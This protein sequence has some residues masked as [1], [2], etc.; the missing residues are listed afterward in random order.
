MVVSGTVDPGGAS[1]T[2]RAQVST[3]NFSTVAVQTSAVTLS[4]STAG[5][6]QTVSATVTGLTAATSYKTRIAATNTVGTTNGTASAALSTE[7]LPAPSNAGSTHTATTATISMDVGHTTMTSDVDWAFEYGTT[8]TYGTSADSG[9]V[10]ASDAD[11]TS[12]HSDL[13]GLSASTTYHWRGTVVRSDGDGQTLST[14]DQTFTTSA[15]PTTVGIT[16]PT[17]YGPSSAISTGSSAGVPAYSILVASDGTLKRSDTS[18]SI[19]IA[20]TEFTGAGTITIASDTA[21]TIRTPAAGVFDQVRFLGPAVIFREINGT[22]S[23]GEFESSNCNNPS[24]SPAVWLQGVTGTWRHWR[25]VWADGIAVRIS[26]SFGSVATPSGAQGTTWQ[27][28]V[29]ATPAPDLIVENFTA[30]VKDTN[31]SAAL[32]IDGGR[33]IRIGGFDP[34]YLSTKTVGGAAAGLAVHAV[35]MDAALHGSAVKT[36]LQDVYIDKAADGTDSY[37]TARTGK[38]A[39]RCGLFT[40]CGVRNALTPNTSGSR[41]D[42]P[43]W[44]NLANGTAPGSETAGNCTND[45]V[46][47]ENFVNQDWFAVNTVNATFR[48]GSTKAQQYE[49]RSEVFDPAVPLTLWTPADVIDSWPNGHRRFIATHSL[50]RGLGPRPTLPATRPGAGSNPVQNKSQIDSTW[51]HMGGTSPDGFVEIKDVVFDP[52]T[53]VDGADGTAGTKLFSNTVKKGVQVAVSTATALST[54]T[55]VT[56][57]VQASAAARPT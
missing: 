41:P 53:M 25:S 57:P 7:H 18:A 23:M 4:D 1:T 54:T 56:L 47:S 20:G 11:P 51:T 50:K 37:L 26:R 34:G 35:W 22:T 12:V 9:T 44:F 14:G 43:I 39:L 13:T 17:A 10:A 21:G 3:D 48:D 28:W 31:T 55:A 40:R 2:W 36:D 32:Q 42:R 52:A 29:N 49:V 5:N 46:V 6:A 15:A 38:Y 45:Q 27:T 30:Q 16:T 8:N 24:G 33:N 19:T